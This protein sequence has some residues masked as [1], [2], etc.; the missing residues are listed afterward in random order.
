MNALKEIKEG[1][2]HCGCGEKTWI[3][4]Y[5]MKS[6]GWMKGKSVKFI[7]GHHRGNWNNGQFLRKG[8]RYILNKNHPRAN[9]EGYVQESL[10]VAE[11]A[12]GKILTPK[13]VVHH[14][15]GIKDDNQSKNLVICQDQS[16]HDILHQRERSYKACGNP[17]WRKCSFCKQWDDPKNLSFSS[18]HSSMFHRECK[19]SYL[20]NRRVLQKKQ[21]VVEFLTLCLL[22]LCFLGCSTTPGER[23]LTTINDDVNYSTPHKFGECRTA[24]EQKVVI[25][26]GMGIKAEVVHC[27]ARD[28]YSWDHA[29]VKATLDG[30]E[31]FMDNGAVMD[32]VWPYDEVRRWVWDYQLP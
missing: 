5:N 16:Y 12:F 18:N 29:A 1:S 23:L 21:R 3:A 6:R 24:A 19:I 20:K 32:V 10:L 26:T 13:T 31:W 22:L 9:P 28:K 30:Q 15:N 7:R 17:L 11:K 25:L 14:I 27:E 2:C 4:S 8:Y